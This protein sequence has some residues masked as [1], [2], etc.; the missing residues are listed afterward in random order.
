M[1][2]FTPWPT[3]ALV[4]V[5]NYFL[6]EFPMVCSADVKASVVTTMGTYHDKVSESCESYFE[7]FRRRTHVTPKSYL[8]FING[9]KTLYSEKYNYI[10]TLAE[11]MNVGLDKLMEASK[12]VAQLSKDLVVKEKE[13]AIASLKAD[14]VVAEVTVS[15]EAA[16]IV[17]NEV[18]VVKDRA[19]K[20]VEGIGQ[21]KAYA[22]EKLEAAKPAL[23]EAKAALNFPKD[24]INEE[25]VELLQPYLDM[26]DYTMENAKKVCGNVAG[27]LAWTRAMATFFGINKEVLPLKANLAIQESRLKLANSELNKAEAQLSDKQAEFDKVKAKCDAA[28]KEKQDL[29]DDAEMCR[30]KMQAASALIDGLSGEKVRWIE[31]SKEFKSQINRL[32]GDVLQL[33]GFLSYCGPFNQSFRNMLLKDIW[34]AELRSHKIPFTE[35]LNLISALVDPPTISEWNLQGLPGDDLS[36]QNGIIVTKATRYPLLIDPQ[37]QGKAWI[38]EKEKANAFQVHSYLQWSCHFHLNSLSG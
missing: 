38:K 27:L 18:Q 11:R 24:K 28:M 21:E 13:L 36:V 6:S 33:T 4:A 12:S 9:Y 1:D 22:E 26:E 15:A 8:S 3:E 20:I 10:N 16:T 25:I 14:K 32:V 17:K 34:E 37:T 31:Q 29:L 7:R 35:N 30:N 2:W 5:S 23:E 19:Q